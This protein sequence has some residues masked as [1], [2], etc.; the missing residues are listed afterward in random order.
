MKLSSIPLVFFAATFFVGCSD[1]SGT[2]PSTATPAASAPVVEKTPL[3]AELPADIKGLPFE[4]GGKCAIDTINQPQK[5]EVVTIKRADGMTVDG[6]A[7]DDKQGTVPPVVVLQLAQGESRYHALL[8]RHG[9]RDDLT[10][11]FGKTEYADAGYGS[12]LNIASLPV[13]Q[14]DVLVIQKGVDKNL[15]CSTYRKLVVND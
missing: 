12:V 6:W 8:K 5:G 11:A 7:F 13:G 4:L 3:V 1:Q 10:K 2:K 9:G 14:F 15:V